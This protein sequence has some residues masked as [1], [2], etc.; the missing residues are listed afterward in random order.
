[1]KIEKQLEIKDKIFLDTLSMVL[2]KDKIVQHVSIPD[3]DTSDMLHV[4][5]KHCLLYIDSSNHIYDE[6]KGY[7]F[8]IYF[9]QDAIFLLKDRVN[10]EREYYIIQYNLKSREI[11]RSEYFEVNSLITS[12]VEYAFHFG[13]NYLLVNFSKEDGTEQT[14]RIF[15]EKL[16]LIAE[17]KAKKDESFRDIYSLKDTFIIEKVD[18]QKTQ[19]AAVS[20]KDNC[21]CQ[22]N[23]RTIDNERDLLAGQ[24]LIF[25]SMCDVN[26][27]KSNETFYVLD[28][29][30]EIVQQ[31]CYL[32]SA[33]NRLLAVSEDDTQIL[34]LKFV[35]TSNGIK[36]VYVLSDWKSGQ[37]LWEINLSQAGYDTS[38]WGIK[39]IIWKNK[40]IF[41]GF[42]KNSNS[43][44]V[45]V[46]DQ[47]DGSVL[48]Y[49]GLKG[50]IRKMEAREDGVYIHCIGNW[51]NGYYN[52]Y[53]YKLVD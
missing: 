17:E 46:L 41:S 34:K 49:K 6:Y 20:V 18:A 9:R 32:E 11:Y 28:N 2:G 51:K 27:A 48:F 1:M 5:S 22:K 14:C 47:R 21:V 50:Y 36:T 38:G 7:Y 52:H 4:N 12:F 13:E 15:N 39:P 42:R 43:K 23:I 24:N 31:Y 16:E 30:L 33:E 26:G 3:G 35:R 19:L 10:N 37:E 29:N 53:Y 25:L 40:I 44:G 45:L 8:P